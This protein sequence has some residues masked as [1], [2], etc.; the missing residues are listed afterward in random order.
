MKKKSAFWDFYTGLML[1][2]L[3]TVT[4]CAS[5]G[6]KV[7]FNR[8]IRPLL[9]DK[10]FKC[11]GFDP[12]HREA[13]LRLDVQ[14]GAFAKRDDGS[15]PIVS[16]KSDQS[17]I[18][19]RIA[20]DDPDAK[21]PP[22]DSGKVLTADQIALIK[23]WIDQGADYQSHWSFVSPQRPALPA[24]S[25]NNWASNPI[26]R[27]ILAKLEQAKLSPAPVADRYQLVR[28]LSL[29]LIGLPPT[30]EEAAA[31]VNDD[32]P[33]AYEKLVER[34]LDSS[35][36]GERW[37]LWWLDL[38]RYADTNG[39]EVDRPRSIW[40]YR[41]WVI[42]AL[43]DDMPFDQ[44]AIEQIAGDLLPNSKLSQK[45]ATGFHRNT[46]FNEEGGHDYEQ[47]RW[48]SIVDRVHTTSTVFLG[49]TM[50]CAQCHTHKFD[51]ITHEE[52]YQFFA[53]LN[54][55]DEPHV[56]AP[57]PEITAERQKILAEIARHE[58]AL[59]DNFPCDSDDAGAR[60][61]LVEEK[62]EAWRKAAA[63]DAR[64]WV[65]LEPLKLASKNG[66]TLTKLDDNS[67]LATGDRPETECYDVIYRAPLKKIT[68]IK[69]EVVPDPR[70]PFG[71]PGRGY[72][73][74][75]GT[76][77]LSEL[78]A[79]A[80]PFKADSPDASEAE[81]RLVKLV[82]P[83][84]S[85]AATSI[86]KSLD[87]QKLTGWHIK[88]GNG[89][90]VIATFEFAEPIEYDA[91]AELSLKFLQNFVHSQTLGRFYIWATGDEG[92]LNASDMPNEVEAILLKP[93]DQWTANE[94]QRAMEYYLSIAP[95]LKKEHQKI[96]ALRKSLPAMPTTL[97]LEERKERRPSFLHA[98]GDFRR[99]DK[100]VS[101]GVPS[102]LPPLPDDAP[103]NRLTLARWL[104]DRK[105][106]LVARVVMNQIWQ[107]Y[108]GRGIVSTPEDFGTQGDPPSHPELL[109]W[110]ACEF[111]D[112]GWSLKHMHRLIVTSAAYRQSSAASPEKLE[113]D[114]ENVLVSRGPRFRLHG[115]TIRD[116]VLAASGQLVD[117]LGGPSVFPPQ[118]EGVSEA[119]SIQSPKWITS[120]GADRYRRAL[121]T[122]RKRGA[123]YAAFAAFDTPAQ[124][125]CS[126]KRIRSNTPLASLTLLNDGVIIEAAQTLAT[127]ILKDGGNGNEAKLR[128]AFQLCVTR[129]PSDAELATLSDYLRRQHERFE[130]NDSDA[131]TVAGLAEIEAADRK[132]AADRAAW[133]MLSRVL[134]NLDETICKE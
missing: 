30:P 128:Y 96:A 134:L 49:L 117:K 95:E 40:P 48:E 37:A 5:G 2:A 71:G 55:C 127:R 114:P 41:D 61:K 35:H 86:A 126:M 15:A 103:R 46:F 90:R 101:P 80:R 17:L 1:V 76:F 19:Q 66:T 45:I 77:L 68:G 73:G 52:Y 29:D 12:Q 59:A 104:V 62:F 34:L 113:H 26:D 56:E 10:C 58:A 4:D 85:F 124:N 47:F 65:V 106:P 27:F 21:M 89:R 32:S 88:G 131:A 121:Y 9:S 16:G 119:S 100:E 25:K 43:N 81:P 112:S 63:G 23:R 93:V 67:V 69:L 74:Q 129:P 133:T 72:F 120:T 39:Y 13:D 115:E 105:N 111:M 98:R 18:Y 11:H 57:Q 108:F 125:V 38:A 53:F 122:H 42:G 94:R 109:D 24:V 14:E 50:A 75:D 123:P 51:P 3:V 99:R 44:F 20:S 82:H 83:T 78:S 102:F 92:I 116:I 31:F 6:D 130:R 7:D 118:P 132:L 110:L 8:Q 33:N 64:K 107:N 28:R 22:P 87:S 79:T 84:A 54:N 70:L 91:G 97:V 36:Y 60:R